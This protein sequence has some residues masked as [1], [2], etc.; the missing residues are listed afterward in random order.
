MNVKWLVFGL[1]VLLL[2]GCTATGS[3]TPLSTPQ[4]GIPD[5][6]PVEMPDLLLFYMTSPHAGWG[7]TATQVLR[8]FDGGANWFIVTPGDLDV[9]DF[10]PFYVLDEQTF[11]MLSVDPSQE[12][13]SVLYR[14]FD[15]GLTWESFSAPLGTA[16]IQFL[17]TKQGFAMSD[18]G[19]AAGSQAV[20]LLKTTDGGATWS[21]VFAHQ[22]GIEQDLPF[23]GQKYGMSYS[24]ASHAWI[25]GN[26]P[27]L[28]YTY[29]YASDDGGQTWE[30]QDLDLPDAY[31]DFYTG[32]NAPIFFSA[33]EGI[34]P[35]DLYGSSYARIF[36]HTTDGG[37]TWI[38]GERIISL[39]LYSPISFETIF[40]WTGAEQLYI[41]H[42]SGQTWQT[43]QTNLDISAMLV[44]MQFV[45]ESTG[46]AL[47]SPDGAQTSLYKTTDG[48]A[49]WSLL[50]P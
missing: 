24:D 50:L 27:M 43:I 49:T 44:G 32:V 39:G 9:V 22:G 3:D 34:L 42:D 18:L 12:K 23:N 46:W 2:A 47:A 38:P 4:A 8:T 40:L 41:T 7:L 11:W 17:D 20:A 48:G 25:G 33:T 28:G 16:L 29:F 36:Y 35:V 45:D 15:G 5:L 1:V 13:E 31:H 14:T 19:A 10:A 6:P 26:I 37:Q 30:Y 21:V